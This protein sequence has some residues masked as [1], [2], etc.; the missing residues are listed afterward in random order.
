MGIKI[1]GIDMDDL[2]YGKNL[3]QI[4]LECVYCKKSAPITISEEQRKEW[5]KFIG[6]NGYVV[7]D[8]CSKSQLKGGA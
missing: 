6:N 1:G 5:N 4:F 7:C 2:K 8:K 3:V